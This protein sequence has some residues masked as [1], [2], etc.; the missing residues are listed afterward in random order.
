MVRERGE[1]VGIGEWLRREVVRE[2]GEWLGRDEWL[3]IFCCLEVRHCGLEEVGGC[4]GFEI[5]V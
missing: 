3:C 4:K 2:M 5:C 1:W